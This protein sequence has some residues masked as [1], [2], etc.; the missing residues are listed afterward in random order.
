MAD[1][2]YGVDDRTGSICCGLW[3]SFPGKTKWS[4]FFFISPRRRLAAN[5]LGVVVVAC[6]IG[7]SLPLPSQLPTTHIM[8][9]MS[10]ADDGE[11]AAT[12]MVEIYCAS[13]GIAAGDEI[14]SLKKCG[15]CKSVRYCSV[16]CQK[17]HRSRHKGE[18]KKRVAEL[19]DEML[20]KQPECSHL[21]DCPLCLLPLSLNYD[22]STMMSCCSKLICDGCSYASMV[23]E[24]EGSLE[25]KCA[26]CRQPM[27]DSEEEADL[28]VM[29]RIKANDQVATREKGAKCYEYKDYSSAFKYWTKASMLGDV[30]AHYR[31]AKLYRDGE[32]VEKDS[33]KEWDH[34]EEA[35]IG[36]HPDARHNLGVRE[37]SKGRIE[38][39]KKN[40]IIAATLGNHESIKALKEGYVKGFVR[41]EEFGA[42][43]RAYQAVVEETKSSQR[44][45]AKPDPIPRPAGLAAKEINFWW[46]NNK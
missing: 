31:L 25:H 34:L 15:A 3:V 13:C 36:G 37:V 16:L 1:S 12:D 40:F 24:V 22:D 9:M 35:S 46:P 27:P 4:I 41:K 30:E 5:P 20:F 39:G 2:C 38:R 44:E 28:N 7:L 43:L 21:G 11:A 29:K 45:A 14:K 26:F 19:R 8:M 18:C 42:A 17:D 33:K 10:G 6:L 23:R 32:G